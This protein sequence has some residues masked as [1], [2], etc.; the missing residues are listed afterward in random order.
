M[1]L[2]VMAVRSHPHYP[3]VL[4]TN[5]DEFLDRPA[6]A[7]GWWKDAPDILGAAI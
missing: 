6:A 3:F 5:R 1:C 4:A 7:A 2:L